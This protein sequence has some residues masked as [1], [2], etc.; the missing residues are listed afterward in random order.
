MLGF[1]YDIESA[2]IDVLKQNYYIDHG[3]YLKP[4]AQKK[5]KYVRVWGYRMVKVE[6]DKERVLESAL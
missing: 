2:K 3:W 6:D 1:R 4:E 5:E